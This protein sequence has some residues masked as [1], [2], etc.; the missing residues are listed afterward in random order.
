MIRR[1]PRSTLF[2]Y[3]TLFRSLYSEM[4]GHSNQRSQRS[5]SHL[6][7]DVTAMKLDGFFGGTQFSSYLFFEQSR[8]DT[9]HYLSLPFRQKLIASTQA[10]PTLSHPSCF[11]VTYDC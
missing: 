3:T 1:P 7:H 9:R 11:A 2:P 8:N 5:C 10:W 6:S 4:L